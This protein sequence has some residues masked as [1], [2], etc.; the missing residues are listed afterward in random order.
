MLV[1]R[2]RQRAI[3]S[4]G[5]RSTTPPVSRNVSAKGPRQKRALSDQKDC[6]HQWE[7]SF[8]LTSAPC[9]HNTQNGRGPRR[10]TSGERPE[11]GNW[12]DSSDSRTT[13]DL[14]VFGMGQR[15]AVGARPYRPPILTAETATPPGTTVGLSANR[16]EPRPTVTERPARM[17]TA[18]PATTSLT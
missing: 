3:S 16:A 5:R 15:W 14:S 8:V 11:D 2:I 18:A 17:P 4:C 9:P 6:L 13:T 1:L 12:L 10:C 7:A